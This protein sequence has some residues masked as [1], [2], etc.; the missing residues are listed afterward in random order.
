MTYITQLPARLTRGDS[1]LGTISEGKPSIQPKTL[2]T[3]SSSPAVQYCLWASGHQGNGAN[4]G[5]S[6][7]SA[8][9]AMQE[10][11]REGCWLPD[12]PFA[13]KSTFEVHTR[14]HLEESQD[15]HTPEQRQQVRKSSSEQ[16]HCTQL[17]PQLQRH[18]Q[19]KHTRPPLILCNHS[20]A[21]HQH[22]FQPCTNTTS[23]TD[24]SSSSVTTKQNM[25]RHFYHTVSISERQK[26]PPPPTRN[27]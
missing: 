24:N 10:P 14:G 3:L 6:C 8:K 7:P 4:L 18:T 13:F 23:L 21:G 11:G 2:A 26:R 20:R 5:S 22:V 12:W 9:D 1:D 17:P 15:I 25:S 16:L 27:R 19:H